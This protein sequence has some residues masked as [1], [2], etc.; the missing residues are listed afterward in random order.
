MCTPSKNQQG[1]LATRARAGGTEQGGHGGLCTGH[2]HVE[3]DSSLQ[4]RPWCVR[5][6]FTD[7]HS[8]FLP[9]RCL[10]SQRHVPVPNKSTGAEARSPANP[11]LKSPFPLTVPWVH[12]SGLWPHKTGGTLG[13]SGHS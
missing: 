8:V 4:R 1:T 3:G 7:G 6:D 2:C 12:R 10:R 13:L 5:A 9:R 11:P